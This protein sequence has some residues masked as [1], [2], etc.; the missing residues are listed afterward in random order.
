[1]AVD[2]IVAIGLAAVAL[3]FIAQLSRVMRNRAFHATLRKSIESGQPLTPELVEKLDRTPEPR[4]ADQR[5][6]FVLVALGLALVA[7][8]AINGSDDLRDLVALAMFPLF[9]GAALLLR[10][11]LAN[12]R[13]VEP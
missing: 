11:R 12:T 5:I 3:F 8:A 9:V 6:G 1:M 2:I 4:A 7:A 13:Q 10:L